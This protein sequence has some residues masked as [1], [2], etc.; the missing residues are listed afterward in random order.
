MVDADPDLR[1]R[2]KEEFK[3]WSTKATDLDS[4]QKKYN[5]V[6]LSHSEAATAHKAITESGEDKDNFTTVTGNDLKTIRVQ[7]DKFD[8]DVKGLKAKFEKL[9]DFFTIEPKN[10]LRSS[11]QDFFMF[12]KRFCKEIEDA[13]P[14]EEKKRAGAGAATKT[15]VGGK[16]APP[17]FHAEMMKKLHATQ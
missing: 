6:N 5:D 7:L 16:A 14:K 9:C 3:V 15:Q 11:S 12:F 17:S 2:Y 13:L 8:G 1:T 10:D 4:I